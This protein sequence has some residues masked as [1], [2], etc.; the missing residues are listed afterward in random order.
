MSSCCRNVVLHHSTSSDATTNATLKYF[1]TYLFQFAFIKWDKGHHVMEPFSRRRWRLVDV[2]STKAYHLHLRRRW[3]TV[4][5]QVVTCFA[6]D[7]SKQLC[8]TFM[9]TFHTFLTTYW[10]H[11]VVHLLLIKSSMV[12]GSNLN[13]SKENPNASSEHYYYFFLPTF[14]LFELYFCLKVSIAELKN[15]VETMCPSTLTDSHQR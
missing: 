8:N 10:A 6:Y 7:K 4:L 9:A 15:V 14:V 13:P 12:M 5:F 3:T 11:L 2:K 1:K